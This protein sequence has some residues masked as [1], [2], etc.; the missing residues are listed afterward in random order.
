MT[1]PKPILKR[2]DGDFEEKRGSFKVPFIAAK[3]GKV[4]I[5]GTL[6]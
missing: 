3:P 2:A 5:A 1:F 6:S 4:T